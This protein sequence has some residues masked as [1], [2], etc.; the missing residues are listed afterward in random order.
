MNC[1]RNFTLLVFITVFPLLFSCSTKV[2]ESDLKPD[3]SV[4]DSCFKHGILEKWYPLVIDSAGGYFS[5]LSY[6]WT[7]DSLQPKMLVTQSRH[8]WTSSQAA[9][10]YNDSSY[11]KYAQH[12]VDFL[13]NHMWDK[14]YGGFFNIRS[15]KGE[16]L[17]QSYKNEKRAYGNS[18]AIYGLTSY[19][20][21]TK[22]TIAL[23]YAKK[24]FLWLEKYSH[25]RKNG[26]YIDILDQDGTWVSRKKNTPGEDQ[27]VAA[28]KDYNSS[29]HLLESF[30]ELYKVWPD[31]LVKAR[32]QEM[33]FLIRDTFVG[34]KGY[35]TL[36]FT[37]DWKPVS[38][39]DS[40]NSFIRQYSFIDHVS[41]GHDVETAFLMLE[42][43]NALGL[44]N[45]SK[46]LKVAKELVDHSLAAGFDKRYGGFFYEGF[47]FK[48]AD[49]IT[50]INK[51]KSWWVQAEGLN[52]LLMMSKI[53][54]NDD[55]YYKA[56]LKQWEQ[57]EKYV[58]DPENGDWFI[59]GLDYNP[60]AKTAPKASIW[61]AN[62]HNGRALMNCL[63]MLKGE[64]EV[65]N[66][67]KGIKL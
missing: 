21:L 58:I 66:H 50:I 41:F 20:N 24:T 30:T 57:I 53:F 32:L 25:D 44:Q 38:I 8:I 55:Q 42:A 59:S 67:F 46:T 61:K 12:G 4:F 22:D 14:K 54:P 19:F 47:Y 2:A 45:D 43:S 3:I 62:Y 33:L 27:A 48:G 52:A 5:N 15:R 7:I 23:D 34:N 16:Y 40:S 37:E 1:L 36:Y 13:I 60:E 9:L 56:F 63:R 11:T 35:L 10:F 29:I 65:V 51:E 26:G 31:S 28:W 6:N 17:D 49:T 64:N 39:R 18:F